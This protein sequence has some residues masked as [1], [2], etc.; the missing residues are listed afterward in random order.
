MRVNTFYKTYQRPQKIFGNNTE[1]DIC[2]RNKLFHP[3]SF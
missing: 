1:S 2:F 3:I